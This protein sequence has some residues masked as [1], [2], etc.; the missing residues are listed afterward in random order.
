MNA[1]ELEGIKSDLEALREIARRLRAHS[2]IPVVESCARWC[3]MYSH[4]ALWSV[5]AEDSYR[6]METV[7]PGKL[8]EQKEQA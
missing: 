1:N 3:E 6:F 4:V 2:G 8:T 5:G 7:E